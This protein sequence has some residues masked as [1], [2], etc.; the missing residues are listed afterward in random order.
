MKVE[1][2]LSISMT[3]CWY[4]INVFTFLVIYRH[5]RKLPEQSEEDITQ[6][7]IYIMN[8]GEVI[9]DR[10]SYEQHQESMARQRYSEH[11]NDM[12]T[13]QT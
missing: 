5:N 8:N 4:V 11:L 3:S 1:L 12:I 13:L 9:M 10:S 7:F 2:T 6:E